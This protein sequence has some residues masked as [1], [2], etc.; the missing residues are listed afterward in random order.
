M[1]SFFVWRWTRDAHPLHSGGQ[2]L[3]SLV[4]VTATVWSV[5]LHRAHVIWCR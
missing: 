4:V 3:P 5:T 1:R 2:T